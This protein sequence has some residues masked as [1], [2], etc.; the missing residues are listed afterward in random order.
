MIPR[1]WKE[2][3]NLEVFVMALAYFFFHAIL[4]TLPIGRIIKGSA[5]RANGEKYEYRL[6]GQYVSNNVFFF[7]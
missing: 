2:Y 3:F 7:W 1:D 6:S 4:Y 5:T